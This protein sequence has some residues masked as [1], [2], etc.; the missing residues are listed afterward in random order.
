MDSMKITR[1]KATVTV[2]GVEQR[3]AMGLDFEAHGD[4]DF[5]EVAL[6]AIEA[7]GR[8]VV[9]ACSKPFRFVQHPTGALV[10]GQ[11]AVRF[12]THSMGSSR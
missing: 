4:I 10:S 12:A 3:P 11:V 7:C 2:D 8:D 5:E 9:D 6:W 1:L